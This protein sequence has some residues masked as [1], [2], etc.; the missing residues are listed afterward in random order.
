MFR[1]SSSSSSSSLSLS[2]T[3]SCGD[4]TLIR[5]LSSV[6]RE[7]STTAEGGCHWMDK[8]SSTIESAPSRNSSSSSSSSSLVE[9]EQ[10][11]EE[12]EETELKQEKQ[13]RRPLA[14]SP[15][16]RHFQILNLIKV[17]QD[18]DKTSETRATTTTTSTSTSK[19]PTKK[20]FDLEEFLARRHMT[21]TQERWNALTMLP[22][23]VYCFIYL[24]SLSWIKHEYIRHEQENYLADPLLFNPMSPTY[25]STTLSGS[26]RDLWLHE[27]FYSATF[28]TLRSWSSVPTSGCLPTSFPLPALPPLPILAILLGTWLHLPFPF[29][30]HW[31]YANEL[32]RI[33]RMHHWTRRM[34]HA[35]I[36]FCSSLFAY[37]TSGSVDYYLLCCCFNFYC[38]YEHFQPKLR[39][40]STNQICISIAISSYSLPILVRAGWTKFG[41]FWIINATAMWLFSQY[42]IGG[43]SHAA[44]H[45]V[46]GWTTP[47]FMSVA[48]NLPMAQPQLVFAAQC[49]VWAQE[50]QS[51]WSAL[52]TTQ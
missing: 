36:H 43:W 39:K 13:Q 31:K 44:F 46:M 29:L 42:P 52:P 3:P 38:M 14:A 5:R 32:D 50:Q 12:E 27:W 48:V 26:P 17:V 41:L 9:Q 18:K 19:T 16:R 33:A 11:E 40:P 15:Q 1:S 45:L 6:E 25:D 49:A 20:E 10:E 8:K 37:G 34:D 28:N 21:K 24:V 4:G 47:L 30:Y 22:M 7:S 23:S 51:G 2:S 35:M